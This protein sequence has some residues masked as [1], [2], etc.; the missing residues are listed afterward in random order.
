M[1]TTDECQSLTPF[2]TQVPNNI[3]RLV[4]PAKRGTRRQLGQQ[5]SQVPHNSPSWSKV[6]W[7]STTGTWGPVWDEAP[8]SS[9]DLDLG[10]CFYWGGGQGTGGTCIWEE[11]GLQV[12][13]RVTYLARCLENR[14]LSLQAQARAEQKVQEGKRWALHCLFNEVTTPLINGWLI[15]VPVTDQWVGNSWGKDKEV[16]LPS[17]HTQLQPLT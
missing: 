8:S 2:S 10:T 7:E 11:L 3:K 1:K 9:P 16:S 6:A 17:K 15:K 5:A 13:P 4:A 12:W 14:Q